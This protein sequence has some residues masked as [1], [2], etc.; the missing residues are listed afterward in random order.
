MTTKTNMQDTKYFKLT[1]K[2]KHTRLL[3]C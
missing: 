2:T 3:V 1:Q